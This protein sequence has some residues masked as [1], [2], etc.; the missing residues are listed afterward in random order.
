MVI[1]DKTECIIK[2][3]NFASQNGYKEEKHDPTNKF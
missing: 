3:E 2:V 1:L